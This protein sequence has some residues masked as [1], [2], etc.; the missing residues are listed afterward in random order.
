MGGLILL[1]LGVTYLLRQYY[2]VAD[3]QWGSLFFAGLGVIVMLRGVMFYTQKGSWRTSSF[4]IIGGLVITVIAV[5]S[6]SGLTDWWPF[7]VI[8]LGAWFILN[9]MMSKGS[10]PRP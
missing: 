6:Y 8:F 7:L 2:Y 1:W 4:L 9:A 5:A 10:H 3:S